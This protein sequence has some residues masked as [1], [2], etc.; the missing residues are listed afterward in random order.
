M[1]QRLM[2]AGIKVSAAPMNTPL[3][4]M[5]A[6]NMGSAKASMRRTAAPWLMI[7][8]TGVMMPISSGAKTN[9]STPMTVI[10]AMPSPTDI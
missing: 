5:V 3:A 9:M 10:T 4:T 2:M 7:S 1:L 6:A 8:S